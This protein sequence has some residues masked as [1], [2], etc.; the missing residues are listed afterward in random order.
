MDEQTEKES[1]NYE[2]NP[3]SWPYT[4]PGDF[5]MDKY[6]V[7]TKLKAIELYESSLGSR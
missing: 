7:E 3:Q 1:N 4:Q 6:T 2:V 5:A